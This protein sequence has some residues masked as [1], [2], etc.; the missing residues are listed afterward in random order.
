MNCSTCGKEFDEGF[1]YCPSCGGSVGATQEAANFKRAGAEERLR[2]LRRR[3]IRC[4]VAG[5]LGL[6]AGLVFVFFLAWIFPEWRPISVPLFGLI[7]VMF[8]IAAICLPLSF[9]NASERQALVKE[10]GKDKSE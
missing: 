9:W 4:F 1:S 10:L 8:V 6:A 3:E 2:D 5:C 7:V